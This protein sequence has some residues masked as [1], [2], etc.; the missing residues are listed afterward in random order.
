MAT[1]EETLISEE[2]VVDDRSPQRQ[3]ADGVLTSNTVSGF[4]L[5]TLVISLAVAASF[6]G[7]FQYKEMYGK[8]ERPPDPEPEPA[9]PPPTQP[10][11]QAPE[12]EEPEDDE[13]EPYDS[14]SDGW[15]LDETLTLLF[16]GLVL[17][18]VLYMFLQVVPTVVSATASGTGAFVRFFAR[19]PFVLPFIIMMLAAF[20]LYYCYRTRPTTRS[21]QFK[22]YI[23]LIMAVVVGT[24]VSFFPGAD[25]KTYIA[26]GFWYGLAGLFVTFSDF[27][28][29]ATEEAVIWIIPSTILVLML[30]LFRF[31]FISPNLYSLSAALGALA[32]AVIVSFFGIQIAVEY[33]EPRD[34]CRAKSF[35]VVSQTQ[36]FKAM[37]NSKTQ[38]DLRNNFRKLVKRQRI[39]PDL[40]KKDCKAECNQT[41][42]QV[43]AV[44]EKREGE[45]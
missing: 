43:Q 39:H 9:P 33:Q 12:E 14:I 40:C 3:Y 29:V 20:F 10:P 19:F 44:K 45:L 2:F 26:L 31:R 38:S 15:T 24:M 42:Q 17:L 5:R 37:V 41:F 36:D 4:I 23:Q 6:F 13:G 25:A 32:A 28:S 8:A 27:T 35:G 18:P 7:Y 11:T 22:V 30:P 21:K 1:E 16:G 34:E